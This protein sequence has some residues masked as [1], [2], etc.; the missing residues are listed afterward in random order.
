M[1]KLCLVTATRAVKM[2][3]K[4]LPTINVPFFWEFDVRRRQWV[5]TESGTTEESRLH[6][7]PLATRTHNPYWGEA[8]EEIERGVCLTLWLFPTLRWLRI[9][10]LCDRISFLSNWGW[11]LTQHTRMVYGLS[12]PRVFQSTK[13]SEALFVWER[14]ETTLLLRDRSD[15]KWDSAVVY[16]DPTVALAAGGTIY[17]LQGLVNLSISVS[18]CLVYNLALL[19][20]SKLL[21]L[22][23]LFPREFY[24]F[25]HVL[26]IYGW[27]IY[28]CFSSFTISGLHTTSVAPISYP[29]SS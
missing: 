10:G 18:D 13:I 23:E 12:S 15:E 8:K 4:W 3:I 7:S 19:N 17:Q 14:A 27:W 25:S 22:F 6:A 5:P 29:Y 16:R 1:A 21:I 28:A 2:V 20:S 24:T 11:W 9:M 26:Y